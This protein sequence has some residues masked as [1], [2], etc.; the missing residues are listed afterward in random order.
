MA[1]DILY[2]MRLEVL[3]AVKMSILFLSV[4]KVCGLAG[5]YRIGGTRP[6]SYLS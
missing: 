5:A 3:R 2:Y 6:Y 4:V 1:T